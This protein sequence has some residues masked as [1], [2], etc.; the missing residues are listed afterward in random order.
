MTAE[1]LDLLVILGFVG[2]FLV[3][4]VLEWSYQRCRRWWLRWWRPRPT[5]AAQKR[6]A[7]R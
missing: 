7:W 1:P 5:L 3:W 6:E 2:L 4:P